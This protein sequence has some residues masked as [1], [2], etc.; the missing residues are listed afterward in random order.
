[1]S[2]MVTCSGCILVGK[3]DSN[4]LGKAQSGRR[5]SADLN[6]KPG[7]A[8]GSG[9]RLSSTAFVYRMVFAKLRL[10]GPAKSCRFGIFCAQTLNSKQS[11]DSRCYAVP[12]S[13]PTVVQTCFASVRTSG[14]AGDSKIAKRCRK[15]ESRARRCPRISSGPICWRLGGW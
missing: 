2:E 3:A 11:C 1:M 9:N 14:M 13:P 8:D 6:L 15:G 4:T 5:V 10:G 12:D 7:H